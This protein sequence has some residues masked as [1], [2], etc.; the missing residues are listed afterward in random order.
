M[1]LNSPSPKLVPKYDPWTT[2]P[3]YSTAPPGLRNLPPVQK[4]APV[5][6]PAVEPVKARTPRPAPK[7]RKKRTP[8]RLAECGS[9]QATQRHKKRGETCEVCDAAAAA[10]QQRAGVG[11]RTP[12]KCGDP[13]GEMRHRR[14]G[15]AICDPCREAQNKA[16]RDSRERKRA[17]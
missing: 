1:S 9:K 8:M 6:Q 16:R 3:A 2:R 5:V 4:P 13:G 17:A 12:A 15:E 14:A 11:N 7:E 10:R